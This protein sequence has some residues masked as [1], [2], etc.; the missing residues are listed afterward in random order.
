MGYRNPLGLRPAKSA[1]GDLRLDQIRDGIASGYGTTIGTG[2]PVTLNAG[3]GK[4]EKAAPDAPFA[5]VFQGCE[6]KDESGRPW[7]RAYWPANQVATEI[8]AFLAGLTDPD[9]L[10]EI[11]ADAA[12]PQTAYGKLADLNAGTVSTLSGQTN[13][14]LDA[15]T[16][17]SGEAVEIVDVVTGIPGV[18]GWG[19]NP[20][21]V[22]VRRAPPAPAE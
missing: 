21:T 10:F 1:S 3:T 20:T 22:L 8:V 9:M 2:D 17:G 15:A 16:V 19:I 12:V 14:S 4:V 11:V 7:I 13:A 5:A 6:Y 18:D